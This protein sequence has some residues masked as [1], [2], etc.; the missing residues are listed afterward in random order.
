M[1]AAAGLSNTLVVT[2]IEALGP[3]RDDGEADADA[4]RL[5]RRVVTLIAEHLRSYDLIVRLG[6]DAL[7]CA[8]SD[9]TIAE[10]RERFSVIA[11]A[12]AGTSEAGALRT[13]FAEL[14]AEESVDRA[15]RACRQ[16]A[17]HQPPRLTHGDPPT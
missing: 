10:A 5:L 8:M 15:H 14:T 7:L 9:M 13:G 2:Y 17:D 6:G 12:L 16:R 1:I 11:G 4:D 3:P